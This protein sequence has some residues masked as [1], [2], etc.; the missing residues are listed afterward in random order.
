MYNRSLIIPSAGLSTRLYPLS[1]NTPKVLIKL[2]GVPIFSLLYKKAREVGVDN[3][4]IAV[5]PEFERQVK[6][7]IDDTYAKAEVPIYVQVVDK[8]QEGVL[9]SISQATYHPEAKENLLIILSDTLYTASLPVSDFKSFVIT[10]VVKDPVN[11]WCLAESNSDGTDVKKFWDK[12]QGECPTHDALIGIYYIQKKD[13]NI[14]CDYVFNQGIK[15]RNEYQISQALKFY[16]SLDNTIAIVRAEHG[17]WHDSGTLVTLQEASNNYFL[18]REFNNI[19]IDNGKLIKTSTNIE[20][21]RNQYIWYQTIE[22]KNLIPTIYDYREYGNEASLIME[23]CNLNDLGTIFNFCKAEPVFFQQTMK[24]L[25]DLFD[26]YLWLYKPA[27]GLSHKPNKEMFLKKV[28][29]RI[30]SIDWI[31]SG[32]FYNLFDNLQ[33][34]SHYKNYCHIHG[35]LIL[36]N[37]LFDPQRMTVKL[38]DPRGDYGGL[39][40]FG[41]I[42]YDLAKLLH[43]VDGCY[44]TIIH[45]L[46][47]INDGKVVLFMSDQ[48]KK[49][50]ELA[51]EEIYTFAARYGIN[52]SHLQTIEASLFLSMIPLHSDD[53]KRQRAFYLTAL[54]ILG[55]TNENLL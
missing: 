31:D 51:Q 23:L 38:I 48:K 47:E 50:F 5:A 46:Y 14:S 45:N 15:I 43:S 52:K 17:G 53:K 55:E 42:R 27:V 8:P 1:Y 35:D 9:Y 33:S 30:E 25:I 6:E 12:P 10:E 3:I 34:L 11:R 26:K 24:Y 7:F 13:F 49:C 20:S 4:I 28:V 54:R 21:L 29:S 36:S 19:S 40:I 37:I 2:N 41:D 18:T 32:K 16:M 22:H 44:E 39:G